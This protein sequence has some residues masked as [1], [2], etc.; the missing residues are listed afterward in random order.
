MRNFLTAKYGDDLLIVIKI[1]YDTQTI[2]FKL[3]KKSKSF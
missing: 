1:F 3:V 2:L